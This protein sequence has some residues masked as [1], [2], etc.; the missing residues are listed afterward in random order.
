MTD[1]PLKRGL[2]AMNGNACDEMP[3]RSLQHTTAVTDL[4]DDALT[5]I[6]EWVVRNGE[7]FWVSRVSRRWRIAIGIACTRLG[8]K[9][10]PV[11]R[12]ATVFASIARVRAVLRVHGLPRRLLANRMANG[13]EA[14]PR[15]LDGLYTWSLEAERAMITGGTVAVLDYVWNGW[16]S[17][18]A[19]RGAGCALVH[20]CRVGRIDLLDEMLK[21]NAE[22][23]MASLGWH[24]KHHALGFPSS[25]KLVASSILAPS[26]QGRRYVKVMEW[27]YQNMETITAQLKGWVE[28]DTW[29]CQFLSDENLFPLTT[30]ACTGAD[31]QSA[32]TYLLNG[33]YPMLGSRAPQARLRVQ[34]TVQFQAFVVA[35][36]DS[37]CQLHVITGTNTELVNPVCVWNWLST[38]ASSLLQ[39]IIRF[40]DDD[41]EAE[42]PSWP[43]SWS[44]TRIQRTLF[45]DLKLDVYRW[46]RDR[47]GT[48]TEWVHTAFF[49]HIPGTNDEPPNGTIS[50]DHR[51]C[52]RYMRH[53][54]SAKAAF[55]LLALMRCRA[56]LSMDDTSH[57]MWSAYGEVMIEA[58]GDV[59]VHWNGSDEL[60]LERTAYT[61]YVRVAMRS[62]APACASRF[63]YVLSTL[64]S[65][66]KAHAC[67]VIMPALA[68]VE[69][70]ASDEISKLN[71]LIAEQ[72]SE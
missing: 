57:L 19:S 31:A 47:V 33:I 52:I 6:C 71:C 34:H 60:A 38:Q 20:I 72:V 53:G 49:L 55:A 15:S 16:R 23:G 62:N 64:E 42:L 46:M 32:L 65:H 68:S 7:A 21:S 39:L 45:R 69:A 50:V 41:V 17:A 13:A 29:R 43:R 3:L 5:S 48:R 25:N 10:G 26:L 9:H 18:L 2:S 14:R 40:S 54:I 12:L 36:N 51:R 66:R 37:C 11:S 24:M 59:L 28:P 1:W 70:T 35:L 63:V 44:S 22:L 27:Y 61:E 4:P 8:L 56:Q 58:L 30:A 67:R